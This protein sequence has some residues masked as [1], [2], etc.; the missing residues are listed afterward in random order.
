MC[1][2]SGEGY[3]SLV[4]RSGVA[5]TGFFKITAIEATETQLDDLT[6]DCFVTAGIIPQFHDTEIWDAYLDDLIV[7]VTRGVLPK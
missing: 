3:Q 6:S 1:R 2:T 5:D 7:C 4:H